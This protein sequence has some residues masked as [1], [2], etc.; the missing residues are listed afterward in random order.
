MVDGVMLCHVLIMRDI[1]LAFLFSCCSHSGACVHVQRVVGCLLFSGFCYR[2]LKVR[3][4]I[5]SAGT[6]ASYLRLVSLGSLCVW[7]LNHSAACHLYVTGVGLCRVYCAVVFCLSEAT[8]LLCQ[9]LH[10]TSTLH[11]SASKPSQESRDLL[12]CPE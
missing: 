12:P 1:K 6:D 7:C 2:G 9:H 8:S 3:Y 10:W 11:A 5:F 4:E